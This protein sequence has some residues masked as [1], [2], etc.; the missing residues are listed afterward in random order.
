M[1]FEVSEQHE[2]TAYHQFLDQCQQEQQATRKRDPGLLKFRD[3]TDELLEIAKKETVA[4]T[5]NRFLY[6]SGFAVVLVI[7]GH[8]AIQ[9][10]SGLAVVRL[11]NQKLQFETELATIEG[12]APDSQGALRAE[13]AS[14]LKSNSA[15]VRQQTTWIHVAAGIVSLLTVF[16]SLSA[17]HSAM[18]KLHDSQF[19]ERASEATYNFMLW[20][21]RSPTNSSEYSVFFD[22]D[23]IKANDIDV[24]QLKDLFSNV[25]YSWNRRGIA[26]YFLV[27]MVS[28]P[29]VFIPTYGIGLYFVL[30]GFALSVVLGTHVDSVGAFNC[31]GYL[32]KPLESPHSQDEMVK[33]DEAPVL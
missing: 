14:S 11:Q 21:L 8:L 26:D 18:A 33:T 31:H 23:Q 7:I 22:F 16:F 9:A 15:I 17:Y 4:F 28:I 24:P 10:G 30:V 29:L 19:F 2:R 12:L 13:S 32:P 3:I 5:T 27:P 6:V 25:H 1:G 20:K